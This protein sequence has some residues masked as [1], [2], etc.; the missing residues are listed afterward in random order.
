ML[1]IEQSSLP[2]RVSLTD[3]GIAL[4]SGTNTWTGPQTF[5]S[6]V[7]VFSHTT[8]PIIRVSEGDAAADEKNWLLYANSGVLFLST[9][10]DASPNSATYNFLSVDRTGIN[11]DNIGLVAGTA[12]TLSAPTVTLT[13]YI[14]QN[15]TTTTHANF[16]SSHADG[17]FMRF[18]RS[19]VTKGYLGNS[20]AVS[21][22]T[23]DDI[24][25]YVNTNLLLRAA[26]GFIRLT[27]STQ[28]EFN[29]AVDLNGALDVSGTSTLTGAV[30]M[31]SDF[32]GDTA[33]L[34]IVAPGTPSL[35]F[36]KTNAA[37]NEERWLMYVDSNDD[38]AFQTRSDDGSSANV[39]IKIVRGSGVAVASLDFTATAITLNGVAATD[40][41][42][43]S[44]INTFTDDQVIQRT[45]TTVLAIINHNNAAADRAYVSY[46]SN[47]AT[48]R[49]H[50][51]IGDLITG[52][53]RTDFNIRAAAG[54]MAFSGNDGSTAHFALSSTG[55]LTTPNA[56]AAEVGYKGLPTNSQSGNYTIVKA[57][58]GKT[59]EYT[60]A[61]GHTFTI[62]A[63]DS[64]MPVD[65]FFHVRNWGSGNLSI[66]KTSGNLYLA[67][68]AFGTNG[69]RTLAQ[70]GIA[71]F[72]LRGA[73]NWICSGAGL[74]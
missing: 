20:K 41:A 25:L 63:N 38:W 40:F 2:R 6:Q 13:G 71:T 73:D 65:S 70:G 26:A 31:S 72:F 12:I 7:Q 28:I 44:Q 43:K 42:R 33:S 56:S 36:R 69:T 68:T 8:L 54:G 61:G 58:T 48:P 21:N 50:I 18:Q 59:V 10:N 53:T 24:E 57:D 23:L 66:A 29:S 30:L 52:M 15:G 62:D 27:A 67:G 49:V 5:T 74:T 60:G 35:E 14:Q 46:F 19:A 39:P 17:A 4:L 34:R 47:S 37:A 64:D 45:G 32:S 16:D 3:M 51:G 22:G 55:V 11:I 9:A 1:W